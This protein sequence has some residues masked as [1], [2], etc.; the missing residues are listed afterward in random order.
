MGTMSVTSTN[1][2]TPALASDTQRRPAASA[3]QAAVS[4]A[5]PQ[6]G[7]AAASTVLSLD[8][9]PT[10]S[11]VYTKPAAVEE[12]AA[13]RRQAWASPAQDDV[14]AL[15]ARN[16]GR[17]R[18]EGLA[19]QWRGL[20]GALLNQF[21]STGMA[22][23]QT[24][25]HYS[26]SGMAPAAT[27]A[28]DATALAGFSSNA[29]KVSLSIQTRSGQTV[30]LRIAVD[31]ASA[32]GRNGLQV[33][34]SASG[35]L[36][37]SEKKA[38]A[39]LADGLDQALEG[40]G[41]SDP[42]Q[43]DITGLAGFDRSALHSLDLVVKNPQADQPLSS[44]ALHLGADRSTLALNGSLGKVDVDVDAAMLLGA[45]SAQQREASLAALLRS[46]DA[47]A[48]RSHADSR[49]V[50]LFKDAFSQLHTSAAEA[51]APTGALRPALA[52]QIQPLHSGLADFTASFSG[53]YERTGRY[54]GVI[55]TGNVDY[56]LSQQTVLE[57]IPG[58]DDVTATQTQ[59]ATLNAQ[60]LRS[61]GG[62]MLDT[63]AG[64]YD[65]FTV[66]DQTR[67][68]TTASTVDGKLAVA[69]RQT[70]QNWLQTVQQLANF[71][72]QD[73]RS[74]PQNRSWIDNLL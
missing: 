9:R 50:G 16:S 32:L 51:A 37:A 61:R 27:A 2:S 35:P 62:V 60:S 17:S 74:T 52:S 33:E 7:G 23:R 53:A 39:Q 49:L 28:L 6:G 57:P 30:E 20:G 12:S 45:S 43:L 29:A 15:M 36:S 31:N 10:E 69:Q 64:N 46:F 8:S 59:D 38:L 68:T 3:S 71:L 19:G 72:V 67:T 34:I 58:T 14:S 63:G 55:E 47:A 48:D 4:S 41:Q 21:A 70:E 26:T 1:L 44:F 24:L 66:Q 5:A 22:Y 56:R 54:G 42:P 18:S 11:V 73:E 13:T 65:V 25:V 40:L